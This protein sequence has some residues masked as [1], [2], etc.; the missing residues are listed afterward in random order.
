MAESKNLTSQ[1]ILFLVFG[2]GI[3]AVFSLINMSHPLADLTT[4]SGAD[5]FNSTYEKA[6]D[7]K[8]ETKLGQAS[9]FIEVGMDA[10]NSLLTIS[11]NIIQT[12]F[13]TVSN[14]VQ[15]VE[16]LAT[17]LRISNE[18]PWLVGLILG[19][20]FVSFAFAV[21]AIWRRWQP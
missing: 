5:T 1:I 13:S 16:I 6:K 21:I 14:T 2:A 4:Y 19:I 15:S 20:I 12:T 10:L 3:A 11:T 8:D 9:N 17:A 18:A 7:L